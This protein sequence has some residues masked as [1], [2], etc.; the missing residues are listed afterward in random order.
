MT[1][2]YSS[3]SCARS[4]SRPPLKVSDNLRHL[5]PF[6]NRID[7]GQCDKRWAT[8]SGVGA[9]D[10][11]IR[12]A[13]RGLPRAI[14]LARPADE[15]V[16]TEAVADDQD[17][18]ARQVLSRIVRVDSRGGELIGRALDDARAG[19]RDRDRRQD[20]GAD[21]QRRRAGHSLERR[22]D[23]RG[24]D[25]QRQTPTPIDPAAFEIVA[26]AVFADAHVTSFVRFSVELSANVPVAVNSSV[27]PL[28]TVGSAGVIAIDSR[29][30]VTVST[31]CAVTPSSAALIVERSLLPHPWPTL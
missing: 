15:I 31:A 13:D 6:D 12:G 28:G 20:R 16:A 3:L 10:P 19:R 17:H 2:R 26:V 23:R 25:R 4:A 30:G 29:A 5:V 8:A 14:P 1:N 7:V 27:S 21:R 18:E 9:G 22:A 24:A 11:L